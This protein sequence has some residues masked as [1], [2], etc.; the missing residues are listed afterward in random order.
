MDMI[1]VDATVRNFA[2][3]HVRPSGVII[4][5]AAGYPGTIQVSGKGMDINLKNIMGLI[6]MGLQKGDSV[7]ISVSGPDEEK[8]AEELKSLFEK[9]FDFPPRE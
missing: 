2:G 6:A 4:K 1:T 5:A 7:Q 9:E 3:I 8:T